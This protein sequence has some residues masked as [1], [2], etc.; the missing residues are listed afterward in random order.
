MDPRRS[1]HRHRVDNPVERDLIRR[2]SRPGSRVLDVGTAA[3]GRSGEVEAGG[4]FSFVEASN[5]SGSSGSLAALTLLA[6]VPS[7]VFRRRPRRGHQ[8]VGR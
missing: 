4:E 8:A 5:G 2:Y 7:H 6:A 3:A 1:V